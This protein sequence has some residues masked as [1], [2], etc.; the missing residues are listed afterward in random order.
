MIVSYTCQFMYCDK[1]FEASR[2]ARVI[3]H[4][5]MNTYSVFFCFV[6]SYLLYRHAVCASEN[7]SPTTHELRLRKT[8]TQN[9]QQLCV[10]VLVHDLSEQRGPK[11]V[12]PSLTYRGRSPLM[13]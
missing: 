1:P 4:R 9:K 13:S 10:E 5:E 2:S 11:D 6:W 12:T 8:N 7:A 3:K